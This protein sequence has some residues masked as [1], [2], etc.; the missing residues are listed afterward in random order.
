MRRDRVYEILKGKWR[1]ARVGD[2]EDDMFIDIVGEMAL[3][4]EKNEGRRTSV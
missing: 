2:V 4:K 1:A 3:G